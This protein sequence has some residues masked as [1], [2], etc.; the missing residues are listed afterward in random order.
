[1]GDKT[2]RLDLSQMRITFEEVPAKW[3]PL[4][5]RGLTST[6]IA[7][8]VHTSLPPPGRAEQNRL[9]PWPAF[10]HTCRQCGKTLCWRQSPLTG[11]IKEG[12]VCGTSA[13]ILAR[14]GIKALIIEGQP[15]DKNS[16]YALHIDDNG[17]TIDVETETVGMGNFDVV[18]TLTSRFG[19]E[20]GVITIG[21]AGEMR[22]CGASMFLKSPDTTLQSFS[23]G[24]LGAVM[25]SKNLKYISIGPSNRQVEL[26]DKAGFHQAME[27]FVRGLTKILSVGLL[28]RLGRGLCPGPQSLHQAASFIPQ[29][30]ANTLLLHMNPKQKLPKHTEKKHATKWRCLPER[31]SPAAAEKP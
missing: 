12:N 26:A 4:G 21:T 7:D 22:M 8:E 29:E 27:N 15:A 28:L 24:G 23:R 19:E 5:G 11:T 10:R 17:A 13:S 14:V 3:S 31:L 25:G 1:M 20:T 6:I 30:T 16:W 18:R 9:C 2:L